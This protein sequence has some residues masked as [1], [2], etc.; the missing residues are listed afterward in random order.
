M[1]EPV[2]TREEAFSLTFS[3]DQYFFDLAENAELIVERLHL[4]RDEAGILDKK[5]DASLLHT[6][7]RIIFST[8]QS[9]RMRLNASWP[10]AMN[11]M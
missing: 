5:L 10:F 2:F 8:I 4:G 1:L 7:S 6:V 9:I 11:P 3:E